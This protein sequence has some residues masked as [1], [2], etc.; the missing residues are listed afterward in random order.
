LGVLMIDVDAQ[1]VAVHGRSFVLRSRPQIQEIS[2]FA[3]SVPR[4]AL[5]AMA[6]RAHR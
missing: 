4:G 2:L 1:V 3:V 5:R 6:I